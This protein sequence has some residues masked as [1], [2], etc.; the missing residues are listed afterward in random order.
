MGLLGAL[1]FLGGIALIVIGIGAAAVN[2]A[3][4]TT[5]GRGD[6]VVVTDGRLPSSA[7]IIVGVLTFAI[8]IVLS[9]FIQIPAGYI[10][11][12]RQFGAVTGSTLDPGL[13]FVT[14]IINSVDQLD[15]RVKAIRVE[16]YTAASKEQQDL[17]L[18]ATLNYHVDPRQ[19]PRIVQDLGLDFEETI[20]KPRFLDIPKSVTDDYPT[21]VVLNSRDEIRTKATEL[22][23]A[24]LEPR[25][26]IVDGISFENFSYSEAY[27]QAIEEK[28]AAQQQVETER[29]RLAQQEI[30]AQQRVAT[31]RGE[32]EAQIERA[33]GEAESNRLV[34]ASLTDEILQNRYIEK[35][36]D[37]INVML[38]PSDSGGLILDLQNLVPSPAASPTP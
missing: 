20:I 18:D 23:R 28:Q 7:L 34:A 25:G 24:Q 1:L 14:P 16:G 4:P 36:A 26:I 35:L 31:A 3:G 19:A 8:G 11:V 27:N 22:L 6:K 33:R 15:T 17:F 21:A 12:V 29:Q 30:I 5:V 38:V 10:G 32:A 37:D 13:H 2:R 9:A